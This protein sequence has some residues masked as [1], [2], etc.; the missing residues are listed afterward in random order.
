MLPGPQWAASRASRG[1]NEMASTIL[2]RSPPVV[3]GAGADDTRG[4]HDFGAVEY[5]GG[6][7]VLFFNQKMV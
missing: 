3:D 5:K 1:L 2:W 6:D 4:V 7:V